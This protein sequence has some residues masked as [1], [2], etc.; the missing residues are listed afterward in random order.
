M[1]VNFERKLPPHNREQR[2][3]A[4]IAC[5]A[6]CGIVLRLLQLPAVFLRIQKGFAQNCSRCHTRLRCFVR[7]PIYALRVFAKGGFH[8]NREA[9]GHILYG[10]ARGFDGRELPA[11]NVCAAGACDAGRNAR[12]ASLRKAAVIRVDGIDCAQLGCDRVRAF[13]AV[14]SFSSHTV[15]P[16]ADMAMGI[17]DAGQD[18]AARNI[19]HF[20]VFCKQVF[21]DCSD[22]SVFHRNVPHEFGAGHGQKPSVF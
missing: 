3:P 1:A 6:L 11:Y 7:A 2:L 10:I 15:L 4:E 19:P 17:H 21:T 20:S 9:Q 16:H 8:R 12:S 14:R 5:R 18:I 22:F 13:V